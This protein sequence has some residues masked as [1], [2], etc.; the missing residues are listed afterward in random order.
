MSLILAACA[1][2]GTFA[3]A[4]EDVQ[5]VCEWDFARGM[6]GWVANSTAQVK[7]DKDGIVIETDGR[8]PQLMSPTLDI[9]P[10]KGDVLEVQI[11]VSRPGE[12]QWFWRTDT[13]GQ[14]GGLSQQQS[15]LA[16]AEQSCDFQRV[17]ARPFWKTDK[18][19][20]GL[21]F[22]LPEGAPGVYRIAAIRVLRGSDAMPPVWRREFRLPVAPQRI[23]VAGQL[24][25]ATTPVATDYTVAM[26]YFAAWEPEYTWDGWR[27]VA[28]RAPWRLPLLFDSSDKEMTYNGIQF[29][30]ASNPRVVDWHVH[31]M[32]EHCINLMLWD[33]YPGMH[34]D[35]TFDPTFFGNRALEVGFLRK[36]QLGGPA[37]ATN[38]FAETMPFAI[39]WTNHAPANRLGKGLAEYIVDQFLVQ[40]NYY[41][42]DGKA[43]L[44]LWSPSD[45]VSG[46]GGQAEAKAALDHLREY[47]RS[48]GVPGVYVVA[49]NGAHSREQ[50]SALGIDGAMG[51]NVL[52]AGGSTAEYRPAGE[53]VLEDRLEDFKSQTIRGHEALWA[54]MADAFGRDWFVP[55]CPMQ[56][57]EPTLRPTN[58]IM[59]DHTPEAYGELLVAAKAFIDQRGLRKFVSIE[60]FNEWLEGSYVEP[61]TQ[62]GLTYLEA[63]REAFRKR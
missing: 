45:L 58:Y 51:Y 8:D 26:W 35:G 31:W 15:R 56:N 62:W 43:F 4:G 46:A 21:R 50:I 12:I 59:R 16:P 1:V 63:I 38:R 5:V 37:V 57:W 17:V 19:I 24:P 44:P 49:V 33:W 11:A 39:M 27:Q 55:T 32:R 20:I 14:L 3:A 54:R 29:Y 18:K 42:I 61:G 60:A 23:D 7:P 22:D 52:L 25:P 41:K 2:L 34:T 6:Q 53:R 48:R 10:R 9:E 30:R 47:A 13:A 36:E 28:E 40:P